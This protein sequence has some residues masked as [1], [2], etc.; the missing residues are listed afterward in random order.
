MPVNVNMPQPPLWDTLPASDQALFSQHASAAIARRGKSFLRA[1]RA[2]WIDWLLTGVLGLLG[3]VVLGWSSAVAALLL[4]ASFWL[5]WLADIALWA[6]RKDAL[7]ISYRNIT[8]DMR[9]WQIVA[10]LRSKRR[11]PA[12]THQHPP[13]GLSLIVDLVAGATASALLARGFG[14]A[15]IAI[16]ELATS[17]SLIASLF[18]ILL[19]GVAPALKARLQRAPDGSVELPAFCAGQR[20]IGLLIVIFALMTITGGSLA[21][22]LLMGAVSVFFII[23]AVVE[24]IWGVPE[25]I[26]EREWVSDQLAPNSTAIRDVRRST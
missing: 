4:M 26:R 8:D 7:A 13:L 6:L 25:L 15:G 17:T 3:I 20:G 5:G 14:N 23:M 2:L 19:F 22:N 1:R 10:V 12:D 24:L 21:A 16:Q 11:Q 18:A 9:F